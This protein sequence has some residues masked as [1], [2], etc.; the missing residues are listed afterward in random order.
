MSCVLH[1]LLEPTAAIID[2][3]LKLR[4]CFISKLTKLIVNHWITGVL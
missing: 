2:R 4:L 1:S 3:I